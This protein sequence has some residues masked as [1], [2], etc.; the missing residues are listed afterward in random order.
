MGRRISSPIARRDTALAKVCPMTTLTSLRLKHATQD[1]S[2]LAECLKFPVGRIWRAGDD[3]TTP[4][5]DPLEG[6]YQESYCVLKVMTATGTLEDAISEIHQA[7]ADPAV[8]PRLAASSLRKILYC[9][10]DAEGEVIGL[11]AL[12]ML[13]ELGIELE[14]AR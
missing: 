8:R 2:D 5:G 10:L 9:T 7:F 14:I 13:V 4:Q 11:T 3:R 6:K 12:R 1:L